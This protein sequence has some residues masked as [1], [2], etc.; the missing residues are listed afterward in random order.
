MHKYANM[1][2]VIETEKLRNELQ[3]QL[4]AAV[5]KYE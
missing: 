5:K 2:K 1:F 4:K 3:E